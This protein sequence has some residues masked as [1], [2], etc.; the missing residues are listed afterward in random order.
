MKDFHGRVAVVTGA[1][2]GIGRALAEKL[3]DQGM[4]VVLADVQADALGRAERE[5]AARGAETLAVVTDVSKEESVRSLAEQVLARFGAVHVVCNNAGVFAGGLS[6][7]QPIEDYEWVLGVNVWGVI[8]GVRTFVPIMIQQGEEGHIVNTASMAAVTTG[9][10]GGAYYMSKHAVL[11][12][13]ESLYH[14]LQMRQA[15]IGVSALCPEVIATGIGRSDR[16]RPDRLRRKS[17]PSPE[18][19]LVEQSL[20]DYVAA[21]TPPAVIAERVL[22]AIREQRFY[23]LS[24]DAWRRA[25]ETRLED[26]RLGRNPTFAIPT[27]DEG[28]APGIARMTR[29]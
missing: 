29:R 24:E 19:Q 10:L 21:G 18:T 14:E 3:G 25:C 16:N 15:K 13:S 9:A 17:P 8:H 2:S 1:A 11:S 6:W 27:D 4:K 20:S 22:R 28:E 5:I 26:I 12:L 7:E 23:V